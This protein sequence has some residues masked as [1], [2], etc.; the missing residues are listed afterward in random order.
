MG[1]HSL[2][3]EAK[4]WKTKIG[5]ASPPLFLLVNTLACFNL[6][7]LVIQDLLRDSSFNEVLTVSASYYV[8]IITSGVI[9]AIL[10]YKRLRERKSL[11]CWILLGTCLC[12]FSALLTAEKTLLSL[13]IM[14]FILGSSLGVGIPACLTFFADYSKIESRGRI[15]GI[16]FFA[17]QSLTV[18]IYVL[19][20][21]LHI[22][23]SFFVLAAWRLAGMVSVLS[24]KPLGE[25]LTES[26]VPS[27]RV[28]I[29]ERLFVLYFIPWFLFS[30]VNFVEIPL[31]EQFF[32]QEL[33]G[34]YML[35]VI[36]ISSISAFLGGIICD[37]K[38]RKVA[39]ITGFIL[40]GICYAVLNIF[41]EVYFAKILF[42][43]FEGIAWGILYVVF[44]FVVWGDIS[45]G[46]VREGYYLLGEMPFL[47]SGLIQVL[48]QPFVKV[49]PI[50]ASFSLASF[51]LFLAILPLLYALETLPEKE[52]KTRELRDYIEKAMRARKKYA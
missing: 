30:L 38:G 39:S 19:I 47:L 33:L 49:I 5:E 26:I 29:K 34:I 2:I 40:L 35:V 15:G 28:V 18:A 43:L 6:T 50:Y 9:G 11:L 45:D 7:W 12:I 4:M 25:V 14:A 42:M 52:I 48:V 17:V 41:P 27:L 36:V 16:V 1:V 21:E 10:L 3:P 24:Y 22:T 8:A 44:I 31:L 13:V 32:G 20:S 46:K 37:F 51:F 23:T